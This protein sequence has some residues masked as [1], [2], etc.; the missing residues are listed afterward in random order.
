MSTGKKK[1]LFMFE[2]ELKEKATM[3]AKKDRRSLTSL[4]HIAVE[5]YLE[6]NPTG[7]ESEATDDEEM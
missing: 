1:T 3:Q 7:T 5:E 6:R 4:L 2:T